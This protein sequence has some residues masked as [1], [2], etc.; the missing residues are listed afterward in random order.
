MQPKT[1]SP[2]GNMRPITSPISAAA[3][4]A[5]G[6]YL[7]VER[8]AIGDTAEVF[9]GVRINPGGP[10]TP[11]VV[12]RFPPALARDARFMQKLREEALLVSM[13]RHGSVLRVLELGR[14]DDEQF[15]VVELCPGEPLAHVLS[16]CARDG[17]RLDPMLAAHVV[18]Q[19]ASVVHHGNAHGDG[20]RSRRLP[21]DYRHVSPE[22]ILVS[23]AGEVKVMP[24][25]AGKDLGKASGDRGEASTRHVAYMSPEQARGLAVS[26]RSEVFSLGIL[27]WEAIATRHLF[28]RDSVA[29]TRQAIIAEPAP[30]LSRFGQVGAELEN[31]VQRAL[32]KNPRDRFSSALAMRR[33]LEGYLLRSTSGV[34]APNVLG[35]FMCGA[36]P[37]RAQWWHDRIAM[38]RRMGDDA[39]AA[40]GGRVQTAD[41][42]PIDEDLISEITTKNF[43]MNG[44]VHR[45]KGR[46]MAVWVLGVGLLGLVLGALTAASM[47]F[48]GDTADRTSASGA[49]DRVRNSESAP[50]GSVKAAQPRVEPLPVPARRRRR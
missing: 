9:L 2:T 32:A 14:F 42:E 12:K 18:S 27:L 37:E 50:L 13:V 4:L 21:I 34:L 26:R 16:A 39:V 24:F 20:W 8:L 35:T 49:V 5:V 33:A 22:N 11:V 47:R 3:P 43:A 30:A 1:T 31:I 46:S 28:R 29:A 25:C 44:R 36:F 41:L 15:M 17:T 19:V 6:E 23:F 45:T 40:S 38:L 10:A 48:F 7:L